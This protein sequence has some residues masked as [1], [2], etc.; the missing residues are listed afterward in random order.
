M[1]HAGREDII[2]FSDVASEELP[3]ILSITRVALVI[4][5]ESQNKMKDLASGTRGEDTY[6]ILLYLP[7]IMK[8][9]I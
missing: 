3:S 8:Y 9:T 1:R 7:T 4:L 2:F 6:Y 5:S